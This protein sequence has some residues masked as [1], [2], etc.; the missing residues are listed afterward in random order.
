MIESQPQR[1]SGLGPTWTQTHPVRILPA[2]FLTLKHLS[3]HSGNRDLLSTLPSSSC[4]KCLRL[5]RRASQDSLLSLFLPSLTRCAL[6]RDV[7]QFVRII[8][9]RSFLFLTSHHLRHFPMTPENQ[10]ALK[11]A[12]VA[13][14]TAHKKA[15]GY[16]YRAFIFIGTEYFVKFGNASAL[17]PELATQNYISA[18]AEAHPTTPGIPR[19]PKVLF[20]FRHQHTMYIVIEYIHLADSPPDIHKRADALKWLSE[21]PPPPGHVIGPL[22]GGRIRHQFFKNY[23]AHLHFSSVEALERYIEKVRLCLDFLQHPASANK[24]SWPGAHGVAET[25]QAS[26]TCQFQW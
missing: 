5:G 21:V 4:V 16:D 20:D 11:D 9:S 10:A 2:S 23:R 17:E 6:L 13:A 22:G 1:V 14:C 26:E 25:G 24:S 15:H 3:S 12:I 7:A 19:I 8:L 18:Y